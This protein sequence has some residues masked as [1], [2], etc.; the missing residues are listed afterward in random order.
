[1]KLQDVKTIKNCIV[2][3]EIPTFF[4]VLRWLRDAK[5]KKSQFLEHKF[6]RNFRRP[7]K[8]KQKGRI[9]LQPARVEKLHGLLLS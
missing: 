4:Q 2:S 9:A 6:R 7:L 5:E 3:Q 8:E 1:M